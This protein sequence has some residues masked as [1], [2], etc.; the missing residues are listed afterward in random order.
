MRLQA[1]RTFDGYVEGY[2]LEVDGEEVAVGT[3]LGDA[4]GL[5]DSADGD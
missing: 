2:L 1:C 3:L 4:L 5:P